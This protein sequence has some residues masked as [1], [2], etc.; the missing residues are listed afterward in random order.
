MQ[1]HTCN[2]VQRHAYISIFLELHTYSCIYT[3][4]YSYRY[5]VTQRTL[6]YIHTHLHTCTQY[7]IEWHTHTHTCRHASIHSGTH[8][9][10]PKTLVGSPT[11]MSWADRHW[12]S[13][14]GLRRAR[15]HVMQ[16]KADG[17][18]IH[19][20]VRIRG[21]WSIGYQWLPLV[22]CKSWEPKFLGR[23]DNPTNCLVGEIVSFPCGSGLWVHAT[24]QGFE[25]LRALSP[26]VLT[27]AFVWIRYLQ[28]EG[29]KA[30]R[31]WKLRRWDYCRRK[32]DPES[33][34]RSH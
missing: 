15:A 7:H 3:V 17:I 19:S 25:R 18:T 6:T 4:A 14:Q 16:G 2:Y 28:V 10:S 31:T 33:S 23:W 11:S 34:M 27:F 21:N 20:K 30:N 5:R 22:M 26:V 29:W 32:R 8:S 9:H 1:S 13:C 12:G 24:T